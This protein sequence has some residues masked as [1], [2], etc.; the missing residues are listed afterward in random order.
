MSFV[1][2]SDATGTSQLVCDFKVL[3]LTRTQL[4]VACGMESWAKTWL[5]KTKCPNDLPHLVCE[6]AKKFYE[7]FLGMEG[8]G[9]VIESGDSGEGRRDC[10]STSR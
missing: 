6:C 1:P 7:L 9:G 2:L 3:I 10:T 5:P 8:C 4:S